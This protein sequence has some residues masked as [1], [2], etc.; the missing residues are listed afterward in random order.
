MSLPTANRALVAPAVRGSQDVRDFPH[1]PL[2]LADN[3]VNS[4]DYKILK[5][6]IIVPESAYPQVFGLDG[7]GVVAAVGEG[8]S[9]STALAIRVFFQG[10]LGVRRSSA[11]QEHAA[12]PEH[13]CTSCR[14]AKR[15]SD[16]KHLLVWG[17]ASGLGRAVIQLA[18]RARLHRH[19]EP[20]SPTHHADLL[21]VGAAHVFDY[22]LA[23][24]SPPTSAPSP[25]TPSSTPTTPSASPPDHRKDFPNR[26]YERVFG[27]SW[28][29]PAV[30]GGVFG[31]AKVVGGLDKVVEAQQ[32]M[33]AGKVSNFKFVV[34]VH[35]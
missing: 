2:A 32:D 16:G 25:A 4:I 34:R 14:K 19:R 31:K 22:T 26:T 18:S 9:R 30:G 8:T 17:G 7:A 33:M 11:F 35:E 21:S 10:C 3:E 13:L 5:F 23:D 1:D 28:G 12:L 24:P 29:E 15:P 20:A 6:G 27:S